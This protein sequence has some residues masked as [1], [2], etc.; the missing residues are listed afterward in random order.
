[1]KTL[2]LISGITL[3]ITIIIEFILS[4]YLIKNEYITLLHDA[5]G[6]F[7]LIGFIGLAIKDIRKEN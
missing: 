7:L 3:L 1:M 6:L 5:S 4:L 2:T